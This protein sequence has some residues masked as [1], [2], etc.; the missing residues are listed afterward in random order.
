MSF[1]Y[2]TRSHGRVHTLALQSTRECPGFLEQTFVSGFSIS[3]SM[4]GSTLSFE[5]PPPSPLFHMLHPWPGT[6]P[7]PVKHQVSLAMRLVR[8]K[9]CEPVP[10][11]VRWRASAHTGTHKG[12]RTESSVS[13][14][15][16]QRGCE[17]GRCRGTPWRAACRNRGTWQRAGLE[18]VLMPVHESNPFHSCESV[19]SFC[20]FV[21]SVMLRWVLGT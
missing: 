2:L 11:S 3:P 17:L 6:R 21:S 16:E 18:L 14:G 15:P 13:P 9:A 4:S 12:A 7:G 20:V 19:C 1:L 10:A 5:A 8:G